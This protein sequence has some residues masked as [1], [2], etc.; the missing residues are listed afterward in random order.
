MGEHTCIPNVQAV[1]NTLIT[2]VIIRRNI[3]SQ[4]AVGLVKLAKREL[5][6]NNGHTLTYRDHGSRLWK[7]RIPERDLILNLTTLPVGIRPRGEVERV[8]KCKNG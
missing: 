6:V 3:F 7:D 8:I 2:A 4:A 5:A 1:S